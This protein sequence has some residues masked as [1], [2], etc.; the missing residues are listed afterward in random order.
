MSTTPWD[1]MTQGWTEMYNR[2][3]ELA[4][5]W[6]D[7]HTELTTTLTELAEKT[8]P[9]KADDGCGRPQWHAGGVDHGAHPGED[10]AAEQGGLVQRQ[11][12]IDLDQGP[13]GHGG[14]LG[15]PGYPEMVVHGSAVRAAEPA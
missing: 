14:V 10:G 6:F 2:Q 12:G 5:E 15:E 1:E 8:N 9:A 7:G 11:F 3:T 4:K 13:P